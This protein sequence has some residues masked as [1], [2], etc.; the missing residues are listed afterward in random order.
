MYF[1]YEEIQNYLK[2]DQKYKFQR[3]KKGNLKTKVMDKIENYFIS[4]KQRKAKH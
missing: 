4:K 1:D 3:L 2:D